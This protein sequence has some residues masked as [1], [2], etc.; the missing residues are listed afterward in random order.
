MI[1]PEVSTKKRN[2]WS[3]KKSFALVVSMLR[4]PMAAEMGELEKTYEN[5]KKKTTLL[6]MKKF[7]YFSVRLQKRSKWNRW[8]EMRK[9]G[10]RRSIKVWWSGRRKGCQNTDAGCRIWKVGLLWIVLGVERTLPCRLCQLKRKR[11]FR[12]KGIEALENFQ[13]PWI[14]VFIDTFLV[15]LFTFFQYLQ[16][17]T[18]GKSLRKGNVRRKGFSKRYLWRRWKVDRRGK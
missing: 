1:I 12:V 3:A 4:R 18:R 13:R 2:G 6:K 7:N 11:H 9:E 14:E 10:G 5:W 15:S 16:S 8:L 17:F